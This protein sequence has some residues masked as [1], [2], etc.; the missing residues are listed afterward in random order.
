[1]SQNQQAGCRVKKQ[2]PLFQKLAKTTQQYRQM[3]ISLRKRLEKAQ[4]KCG[5]LSQLAKRNFID[6]VDEMLISPGAR[7][8]LKGE[9]GILSVS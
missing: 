8:V 7:L 6:M 5:S 4:R 2:S 9:L 3:A 1:M